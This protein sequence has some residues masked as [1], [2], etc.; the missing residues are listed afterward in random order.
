LKDAAQA[1]DLGIA[2]ERLTPEPTGIGVFEIEDESGVWEVGGY[3]Q[4]PPDRAGLALL[5][6]MHGADDFVIS[7]IDDR[8]WVAQVRRELHPVHA[9]RFTVYGAH[10]AHRVGLERIG[11]RIE[12]AMAFGTGHH[13]TTRGCLML[14]D[15]MLR[16]GHRPRH[17]ADIGC[18]TG[19]L[20]MAAARAVRARGLASDLDPV[21]VATSREN[22]SANGCTA[23]VPV[24]AAAGLRHPLHRRAGYDLIFANILAAPLKR[25]AGQIS[26]HLDPG[27]H[28]ILSGLLKHQTAGIE[29]LFRGH[30]LIC[31]ERL[32]L[33]EWRSLT[34]RKHSRR[35]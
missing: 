28:A 23:L 21:A 6:M 15:R 11:L 31:E 22:L 3:F 13:G 4:D 8:D 16:R 12:A 19:V 14:L 29:A 30:G 9:G 20:A 2:M 32:V 33:G 5:A 7:K 27:G 17:I 24:V 34:M 26:A 35:I 1:E 10:D 18:G 25:M